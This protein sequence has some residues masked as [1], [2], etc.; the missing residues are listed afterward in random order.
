MFYYRF[1]SYYSVLSMDI[2]ELEGQK[3][4]LRL[5]IFLL[6]N[7][8]TGYYSIIKESDIYD[9]VLRLSLERLKGLELI[10]TRVDNTSYPP[11]NMISLTDKGKKVAKHLKEIEIILGGE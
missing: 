8:E 3:G 6:E 7:G 2:R 10:E 4:I 11:R 9:R 1:N 5:L